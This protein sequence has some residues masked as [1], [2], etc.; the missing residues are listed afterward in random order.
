MKMATTDGHHIRVA[1]YN[2]HK[3]RGVD[4]RVRP[5]RI[6]KVLRELDADIIALQEVLSLSADQGG[7]DHARFIARELGLRH[8]FGENRKHAGKMYGNAVLTRFPLIH[9]RNHDI[10]IP[11]REPRGCLRL[12]V[13]LPGG[14]RLHLFNV[15]MG[16]SFPE[17]RQQVRRLISSE[18]LNRPDLSGAR[19]VLGDFNDWTTGTTTRALRHHFGNLHT[20][21][22]LNRKRTYPGL[23]PLLH[24]DQIYF[25]PKLS[26]RRSKV[27]KSWRALVASDHLPLVVELS[28]GARPQTP[29]PRHL[30]DED[31]AAVA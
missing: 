24:L 21:T 11:G 5:E 29:E 15:H 19:I 18:I 2:I 13:S 8:Y 26:L 9:A 27:H 16:T 25:D 1:T 30:A 23:L 4:G 20:P 6:V 14:T 22:R 31:Y 3:C 17:R 12:D 7:D 10:S 28:L